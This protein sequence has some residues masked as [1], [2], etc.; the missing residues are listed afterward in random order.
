MVGEGGLIAALKNM[1]AK[2]AIG[3]VIAFCLASV[4]SGKIGVRV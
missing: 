2:T 4:I 1:D 3:F